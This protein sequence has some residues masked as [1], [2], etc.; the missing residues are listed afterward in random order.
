M[1]KVVVG[2]ISSGP[3]MSR[4]LL[5]QRKHTA[6]HYPLKWEFPGGKLEHG[7]SPE[8]GLQ[9]ELSEELGIKAEIGEL[10]HHQHHTYADNRTFDVRYYIVT[11]FSGEIVNNVFELFLWVPVQELPRYDILEGNTDV[12]KKLLLDHASASRKD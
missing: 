6:K 4:V 10:Y 12:V 3:G 8:S 5:C 11:K 2:I 9:R 1:I 7:E